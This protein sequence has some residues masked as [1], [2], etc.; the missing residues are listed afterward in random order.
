M[1][2]PDY[3]AAPGLGGGSGPGAQDASDKLAYSCA[4]CGQDNN[5]EPKAPIR[6]NHCGCR[7]VFKKRGKKMAAPPGFAGSVRS[8]V[9]AHIVLNR[10]M[11]TSI[12]PLYIWA[13]AM[14]GCC[15]L[16]CIAH[17]DSNSLPRQPCNI[18]QPVPTLDH[19]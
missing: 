2:R 7:I 19:L 17:A 4:D 11:H 9:T 10:T 15:T 1:S 8:P 18:D 6:C 13:K 12:A 5:I 3:G 16:D 14:A